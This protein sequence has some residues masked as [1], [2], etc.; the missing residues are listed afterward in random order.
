MNKV[1]RRIEGSKLKAIGL[2]SALLACGLVFAPQARCQGY[3]GMDQD[4]QRRLQEGQQN[5]IDSATYST[6]ATGA[7]SNDT[8]VNAWQDMAYVQGQQ[9]ARYIPGTLRAPLQS[10]PYGTASTYEGNQGQ[11]IKGTSRALGKSLPVTSMDLQAQKGGYTGQACA[12]DGPG[13]FVVWTP[14]RNDHNIYDTN[15]RL[16]GQPGFLKKPDGSWF[17]TPDGHLDPK[18]YASNYDDNNFKPDPRLSTNWTARSGTSS[19]YPSLPPT[20]TSLDVTLNLCVGDDM[21]EGTMG[22][23]SGAGNTVN[24][25]TRSNS[26]DPIPWLESLRLLGDLRQGPYGYL[27]TQDATGQWTNTMY[28]NSYWYMFNI[29]TAGG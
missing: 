23:V 21:G 25:Y 14:N 24:P 11:F 29:A 18:Y 9:Q 7:Q 26:G 4:Y 2:V 8:S 15:G 27:Q 19:K 12:Y 16:P 13:G 28:P 22:P 6:A 1:E 20:A 3:F 10:T 5:Y 17:R